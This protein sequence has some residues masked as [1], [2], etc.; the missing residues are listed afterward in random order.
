MATTQHWWV[1]PACQTPNAIGV[2]N[3]RACGADRVDPQ[4]GIQPAPTGQPRRR[5][6]DGSGLWPGG[7]PTDGHPPRQQVSRCPR[8]GATLLSGLWT[9]TNCGFDLRAAAGLPSPSLITPTAAGPRP[10]RSATRP[11]LLAGFAVVALLVIGGLALAGIPNAHRADEN[12]AG[13]HVSSTPAG[14]RT[15]KPVTAVDV[16]TETAPAATR[17]PAAAGDTPPA[18]AD[19]PPAARRY[20]AGYGGHPDAGGGHG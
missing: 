7:A 9:C 6:G 13:Q 17:I 14:D 15:P 10:A 1:C 3:C 4:P 2:S 12:E 8:C 16:P 18:A 20:A 11:T 19:T 5:P